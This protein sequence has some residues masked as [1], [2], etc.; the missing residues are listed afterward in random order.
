MLP[1]VAEP[2]REAVSREFDDLGPAAC[3]SEISA[4]L[5]NANPELLEVARKWADDVGEPARIMTGFCMFYRL[6][7]L[8]AQ[9]TGEGLAG[10]TP[11]RLPRVTPEVRDSIVQQIV[12][13]GP[14]AFTRVSIDDLEK[15]NPQLL[16]IAHQF[17]SHHADYLRTMQGFALLY[18]CLNAQSTVDRGRLH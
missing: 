10:D 9:K 3:V 16:Q 5:R 8:E 6:L 15:H 7:D 18:A 2:T 17:A 4:T 11:P 1:R 12:T 14:E 13:Q